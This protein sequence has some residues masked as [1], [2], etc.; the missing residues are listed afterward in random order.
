MAEGNGNREL[1]EIQAT[2][3]HIQGDINEIKGDVKGFRGEI[4]DLRS[5]LSEHCSETAGLS[6]R[7]ADNFREIDQLRKKTDAWS[8]GNSVGA[9]I[10]GAIAWIKT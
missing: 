5:N 1:G 9:L 4:T 7:V 10:A 6:E 8:I 2:L 3:K